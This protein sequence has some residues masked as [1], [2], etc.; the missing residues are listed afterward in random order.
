MCVTEPLA[1]KA[2]PAA[3]ATVLAQVPGVGPVTLGGAASLAASASVV[4]VWLVFRQSSWAWGVRSRGTQ[5]RGGVAAGALCVVCV[6][7]GAARHT[8]FFY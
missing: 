1:L 3:A 7:R 2:F 6:A 4:L 5:G 8:G